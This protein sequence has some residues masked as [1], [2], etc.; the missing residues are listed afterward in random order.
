MDWVE[1]GFVASENKLQGEGQSRSPKR[2]LLSESRQDHDGL[3]EGGGG[4]TGK[5]LLGVCTAKQGSGVNGRLDVGTEQG[6]HRDFSGSELHRW[7]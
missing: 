2:G 7:Q 3:K 4:D 6:E 5:V 1:L